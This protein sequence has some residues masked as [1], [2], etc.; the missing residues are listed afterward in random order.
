[1]LEGQDAVFLVNCSAIDGNAIQGLKK[2]IRVAGGGMMVVKNSLLRR[3]F[4]AHLRFSAL[5]PFFKNQIALIFA[6]NDGIQA[7][8]GIIKKHGGSKMVVHACL[9]EN[10]L[11]GQ[12]KFDLI[13]SLPSKDVL[14]ARL[15]FAL[16]GLFLR[17]VVTLQSIIDKK[18]KGE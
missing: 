9:Y 6:R 15:C 3:G 4:S 5:L 1:L 2:K 12:G 7:V 13:A 11:L 10:Q 18:S 16:Q 8:A 14:H 17:L